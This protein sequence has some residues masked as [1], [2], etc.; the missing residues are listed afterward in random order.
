MITTVEGAVKCVRHEDGRI[1][2]LDAPA[3]TRISLELL[4]D[5]DTA[6]V[7]VWGDR[8]TFGGQVTYVVTGWDTFG[9]ALLAELVEDRRSP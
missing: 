1:E 7:R 9:K 5:S 6:R 4:R 2:I 3:I 8:V